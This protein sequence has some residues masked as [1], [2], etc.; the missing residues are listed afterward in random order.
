MTDKNGTL[1]GYKKFQNY[2]KEYITLF[3]LKD[4]E[5]L[6]KLDKL[7]DMF[8]HVEW[9]HSSRLAT[10]YIDRAWVQNKKTEERYIRLVAFHEILELLFG[11]IRDFSMSESPKRF[12][13]VDEAVHEIIRVFENIF[14]QEK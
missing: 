9:D 1:T 14:V 12:D 10:I 6:F 11:K 13:T 2:A 4:W 8:A 5:I 3:N 7:E